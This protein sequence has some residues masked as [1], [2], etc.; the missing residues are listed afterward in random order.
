[1]MLLPLAQVL[2]LVQALDQSLALMQRPNMPH[3][4]P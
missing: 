1:M 2:Q 3:P 4:G